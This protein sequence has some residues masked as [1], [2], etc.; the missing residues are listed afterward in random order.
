MIDGSDEMARRFYLLDYTIITKD[1]GVVKKEVTHAPL[2]HAS[3]IFPK[4]TALSILW[5]LPLKLSPNNTLKSEKV[6]SCSWIAFCFYLTIFFNLFISHFL[7]IFCLILDEKYYIPFVNIFKN[8]FWKWLLKI[9]PIKFY[10][11]T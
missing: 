8:S 11:K 10:L 6:L 9:L 1:T 5:I 7:K 2:L 4:I 3:S